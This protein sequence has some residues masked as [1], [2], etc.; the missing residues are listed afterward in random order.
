MSHEGSGVE[1]L[2]DKRELQPDAVLRRDVSK[3]TTCVAN[4]QCVLQVF[5]MGV[6]G[7]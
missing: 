3:L 2:L 6:G 5:Q 7:R 4:H 1:H